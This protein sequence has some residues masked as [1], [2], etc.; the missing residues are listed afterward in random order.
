MRLLQKRKY[1]AFDRGIERLKEKLRVVDP[2]LK[3]EQDKQDLFKSN[4]YT[5]VRP[6]GEPFKF[7]TLTA[8]EYSRLLGS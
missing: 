4:G 7:L 6:N 8:E 1:L 2:D 5:S 3:A